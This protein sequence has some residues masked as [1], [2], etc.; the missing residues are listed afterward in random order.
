MQPQHGLLNIKLFLYI[1]YIYT[2]GWGEISSGKQNISCLKQWLHCKD[3]DEDITEQ[4][5]KWWHVRRF[6][7][8]SLAISH[9]F[10]VN[11]HGLCQLTLKY[12]SFF[13]LG[14]WG[15]IVLKCLCITRWNIIRCP[16]WVRA[17]VLTWNLFHC[18]KYSNL[19]LG[20]SNIKTPQFCVR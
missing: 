20:F 18:C 19:R 15:Y 10:C 12:S 5:H 9:N 4:N 14:R 6:L 11:N 1:S 2:F 16:V 13:N 17:R 3:W 8:F 7:S